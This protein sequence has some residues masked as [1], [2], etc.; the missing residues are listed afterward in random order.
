VVAREVGPA[1]VVGHVDP[2][3]PLLADRKLIRPTVPSTSD[4][5]PKQVTRAVWRRPS[6]FSQVATRPVQPVAQPPVQRIDDP[7]AE[8]VAMAPAAQKGPRPAP[9]SMPVTTVQR[10]PVTTS[11]PSI[12]PATPVFGQLVPVSK[13]VARAP[14]TA[15]PTAP[16]PPAAA[17]PSADGT[18]MDELAR[19]LFEPISRLLRSDLRQGRERTGRLHDRRR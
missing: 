11:P 19:R 7:G 15:D 16:S 1:P 12:P 13:V 2:V 10:T 4:D 5:Q 9:A 3:L 8:L 6:D 18:D 17:A 14:A